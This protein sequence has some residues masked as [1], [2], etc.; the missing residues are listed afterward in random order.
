MRKVLVFICLLVGVLNSQ[1]QD[2]KFPQTLTAGFEFRPIFP[3]DFLKTGS[4]STSNADFSVLVA[5]KFSFSAG[6]TIRYGFSKRL[7]LET[8]INFVQRNYN[9]TI[10][11]DATSGDG[12]NPGSPEF[13]SKTDF[14][15]VGYEHPIKLLVFVRLAE[16]VFMNAAGGF[17]L[18]FFPSDIFT[19]D[20][21]N[22]PSDQYFKHS[23]LRLG[24][25]GK[26]GP[27]GFIHGGA[28]ANLGAEYRTKKAGYF[29]LGAT[30]HVPF[31]NIYQSKFQYLDESIN[32]A[33]SVQGIA[34][35]GSYLTFDVRYFF[36]SQPLVKKDRKSKKKSGKEKQ[37][38]D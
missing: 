12:I 16:R 8:G 31:A 29:Y 15:I 33:S 35:N 9:L 2:E 14:T 32:Y 21:E 7:A 20:R 10:H 37:A 34:L 26:P 25:D 4:Q 23:S 13:K 3:V 17:Q 30:Y 19:S 38:E 1:A 24:F 36:N 28:I 5:P 27:D 22:N 6:M 11:R 18:T